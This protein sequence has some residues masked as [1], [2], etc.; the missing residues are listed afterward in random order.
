ML[1]DSNWLCSDLAPVV[2]WETGNTDKGNA[3]LKTSFPVASQLSEF[4]TILMFWCSAHIKLSKYNCL[5]L[6]TISDCDT[7]YSS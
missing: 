2:A 4:V 5:H 6:L 7:E 3:C 1:V